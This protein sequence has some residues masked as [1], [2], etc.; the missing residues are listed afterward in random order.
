M[1]YETDRQQTLLF[2]G[3]LENGQYCSETWEFDGRKWKQINVPCPPADPGYALAYDSFRGVA[4]LFGGRHRETWEFDGAQWN[5]VRCEQR[6]P[7]IAAGAMAYDPNRHVTILFGGETLPTRETILPVLSNETWQY[8]GYDWTKVEINGPTPRKYH[9]M[10]YDSARERFVLF[11]GFDGKPLND[12]WELRTQGWRQ[13]ETTVAP[14]ARRGSALAYDPVNRQT[15]LFGGFPG[16]DELWSF[17]GAQWARIMAIHSPP[18]REG[19]GMVFMPTTGRVL[20]FGGLATRLLNDCWVFARPQP[21]VTLA[22]PPPPPTP[23]SEALAL[24]AASRPTSQRP[25]REQIVP[26]ILEPPSAGKESDLAEPSPRLPRVQ[27][28]SPGTR[29]SAVERPEPTPKPSPAPRPQATP[30]PVPPALRGLADLSFQEVRI[31][32]TTLAPNHPLSVAGYLVNGGKRDVACWVEVWISADHEQYVRK[33]LLCASARVE[34][35]SGQ[36]YDLSGWRPVVYGGIPAG[37]VWLAV[38]VDRVNEVREQDE[39]NNV[40]MLDP[41]Y[42][43]LPAD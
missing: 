7:M 8:D 36:S 43:V 31:T 17:D 13:V 21:P 42:T 25:P 6:P 30:R 40:L 22:L 27:P 15:L 29:V 38:E 20:V 10:V 26:P 34:V 11:G 41:V 2:G 28:A 19:A 14:S 33:R 18:Y 32:P 39:T 5:R 4:I 23:P 9:Q 35:K 37:R 16:G 12:T 3:F 1:V 24:A